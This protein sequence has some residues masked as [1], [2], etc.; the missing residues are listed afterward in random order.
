[1]RAYQW[2][3]HKSPMLKSLDW[4]GDLVL[5]VFCCWTGTMDYGMETCRLESRALLESGPVRLHYI[6]C[7]ADL[8]V[9]VAFLL[10]ALTSPYSVVCYCLWPVRL[11]NCESDTLLCGA[12]LWLVSCL[13]LCC[14]VL[15]ANLL[16]ILISECLMPLWTC[17]RVLPCQSAR[18]ALYSLILLLKMCISESVTCGR[19]LF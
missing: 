9:P 7:P 3:R 18:C 15:S 2:K 10:V 1:M 13:L 4:I 11:W 16:T 5:S 8:P 14:A 6:C 12:H 19:V 17:G